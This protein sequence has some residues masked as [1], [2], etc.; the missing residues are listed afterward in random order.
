LPGQ[1]LGGARDKVIE[2]EVQS[3]DSLSSIA[4]KFQINIATILWENNLGIR[5]YLHPG[6]K[7]RILPVSGVTHTIKKGDTIKK[8]AALYGAS[9]EEIVKFNKLKADGSDLIAGEKILIPNG[10]KQQ[11]RSVVAPRNINQIAAPPSSRQSPTVS[12]FVWPSAARVITQ[13]FTWKHSGL[14]IAGGNFSTANYAAKAGVVIKSQCGWNSGYG[15]VVV[16]DHG[17]GIQ[18]LYGHNSRVLVT[19]GEYVEAGQTIA[20]MGNTGKTRGRTGI[21]LHFEVRVNGVRTNPFRFV[22]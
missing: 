3:G 14:D 13:Y 9:T 12:G 2:Y 20:L 21:H 18:T 8:I 6:D 1:S 4:A 19:P 22:K 15:C 16:I 10:T 5:S 7:L 17:G 11:Q